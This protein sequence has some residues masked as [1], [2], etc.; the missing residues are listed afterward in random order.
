MEHLAQYLVFVLH[1]VT[2]CCHITAPPG[3]TPLRTGPSGPRVDPAPA[4]AHRWVM[5]EWGGKVG[6]IADGQMDRS[7]SSSL[8]TR[9][10][11]PPTVTWGLP[12]PEHFR[13]ECVKFKKPPPQVLGHSR[14][15]ELFLLPQ[16][17]L[18]DDDQMKA[19]E[20]GPRPPS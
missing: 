13:C 8:S 3:L 6:G 18:W 14:N 19:T 1:N 4:G 11:Q 5:G 20:V 16:L 12:E 9:K 15:P 2:C 7:D 10:V 17:L